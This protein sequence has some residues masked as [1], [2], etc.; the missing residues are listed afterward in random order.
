MKTAACVYLGSVLTGTQVCLNLKRSR[1]KTP[2]VMTIIFLECR[3]LM[4][5]LLQPF[6][7]TLVHARAAFMCLSLLFLNYFFRSLHKDGAFDFSICCVILAAITT[8]D[9][10]A[11]FASVLYGQY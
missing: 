10:H 4:D 2:V 11:L 8:I 6:S 5:L 9:C 7:Q 1:S 3:M